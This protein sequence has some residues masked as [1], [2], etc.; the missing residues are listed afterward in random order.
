[1]ATR[2]EYYGYLPPSETLDLGKLTTDLSKTISGIGERRTLE[3][4]ALDQI[5]ADNTKIIRDSELGKSQTFQTMTLNAAQNGVVKLNE[6]NKMLK[7]G[8]LSPK[9][10]KQRM[11]TMMENWGTFANT[12]KTYDARMTEIQKQ[13]ADGNA[14]GIAV[15]S[16]EYFAQMS[17][18][19]DKNIFIDDTGN[20]SMGRVDPNTGQLDPNSVESFR[21]MAL[22]NNMVFDKVPLDQTVNDTVK[23]W[24]PYIEENGLNTIESVKTNKDL[25]R[26]MADL[27]GG[28]TSNPRLTASILVDNT[29]SGY[30]VYFGKE[31]FNNKLGSMIQMENE[32]RRIS[33]EGPMNQAEQNEFAKE[34]SGKLIEMRKDSTDT[35]QPVIT[36]DQLSRAKEAIEVAVS[37]QLGFKS[38]QDEPRQPSGG[39]GGGGKTPKDTSSQTVD[40]IR[41]L[42]I[43]GDYDSLS[44]FSKDK[45]YTF[46]Q[47]AS[48]KLK[49]FKK[50]TTGR[51]TEIGE[52]DFDNAGKYFEFSNLDKW[53]DYVADSRKRIPGTG[54]ERNMTPD[55]WNAKWATLKK[56]QKMVGPDGKTYT[57][58]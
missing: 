48:G 56:G 18:L 7:A 10:Y 9:D 12:V 23:L 51:T 1:M 34:A 44:E 53:S 58:Q 21:S 22:P 24:K 36:E 39:G 57:K 20:M 29:G 43:N 52:V 8:Q 47:G 33:G 30:D 25:A 26:K 46:K 15:S 2:Q 16:N 40:S 49:V 32:A 55:Q 54:G 28:L 5:Q 13:Q 38:T 11:N 31:D 45:Q 3:K 50:N 27:T 35:Y 19:K 14:S 42:I 4:E 6:W 17:S 41:K 37:L